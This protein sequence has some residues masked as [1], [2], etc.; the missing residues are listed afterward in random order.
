MIT[1]SLHRGDDGYIQLNLTWIRRGD[2]RNM[3]KVECCRLR[4]RI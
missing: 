4:E 1:G 2:K 3:G